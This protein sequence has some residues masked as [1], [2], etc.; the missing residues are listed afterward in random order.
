MSHSCKLVRAG[1][2]AVLLIGRPGGRFFLFPQTF[3]V[4]VISSLASPSAPVLLSLP[5]TPPAYIIPCSDLP[6]CP[7]PQRCRGSTADPG[8]TLCSPLLPASSTSVSCARAHML[9][10]ASFP[11]QRPFLPPLICDGSFSLR[12]P[13]SRSAVCSVGC[14]GGFFVCGL[15]KQASSP[16]GGLLPSRHTVL[17]LGSWDS[18]PCPLGLGVLRAP[19]ALLYYPLGAPASAF[20]FINP[21]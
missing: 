17:S 8:L 14:Q 19:R 4:A 16:S 7:E 11:L 10:S 18:V 21:P 12:Q 1:F 13:S 6:Q 3:H 5:C 2:E 15:H 20:I 9:F